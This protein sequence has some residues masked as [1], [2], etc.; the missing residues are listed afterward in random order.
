MC[1]CVEDW[2]THTHALNTN[3]SRV[4]VMHCSVIG[5]E[6]IDGDVGMSRRRS[7]RLEEVV[8]F[9]AAALESGTRQYIM[10]NL[11]VLNGTA[12]MISF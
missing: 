2:H 6:N 4:V 5:C 8:T 3:A 1:V 10:H 11:R 12:Y 9:P 7:V